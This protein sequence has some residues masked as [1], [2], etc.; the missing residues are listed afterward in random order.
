LFGYDHIKSG[1]GAEQM[2]DLSLSLSLTDI[3]NVLKAIAYKHGYRLWFGD[4]Y[5]QQLNVIYV[6]VRYN[7]YGIV[8][9]LIYGINL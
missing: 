2:I 6:F 9:S 5:K 8:H 1:Q 3:L 4:E 7:R